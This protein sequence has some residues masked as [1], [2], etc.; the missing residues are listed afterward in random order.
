MKWCKLT[1]MQWKI[2]YRAFKLHY[3]RSVIQLATALPGTPWFHPSPCPKPR[4]ISQ[5]CRHV[6]LTNPQM[7]AARKNMDVRIRVV[8]H[9]FWTQSWKSPTI[10]PEGTS[11]KMCTQTVDIAKAKACRLGLTLGREARLTGPCQHILLSW[12]NWKTV[13]KHSKRKL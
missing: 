7:A 10:G 5:N 8:M 13:F 1:A 9:Q 2:T 4:K 11:P 12:V 3:K 6:D